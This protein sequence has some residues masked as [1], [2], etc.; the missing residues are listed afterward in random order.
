MEIR[1]FGP[2]HRRP[3]GPAGSTG[4]S[5]QVIH[6]DGRALISELAF[7]ARGMI[8]PHSNPN[9]TLFIVVSGGGFV[10]VGD[11]RARVNHGEAV[12]WPAGLPH[13]AYTEGTE[14]RAI[15]VELT[16]ADDA[17]ARGILEAGT[18]TPDHGR[19][20]LGA[21]DQGP[22]PAGA[23]DARPEATP[24]EGELAER[25]PSPDA[26]DASTGEPW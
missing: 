23:P 1:R 12:L 22:P 3:E 2:G 24:A 4:L 9:T 16:G 18:P 20:A 13:G 7:T 5:G 17:W 26:Y 25:D 19:P 15:V 8:A 11:E 6:E 10:Q 14:M 21:G